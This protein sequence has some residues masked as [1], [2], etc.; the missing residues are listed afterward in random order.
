M[1]R[2]ALFGLLAVVLLGSLLLERRL[3]GTKT[4]P[5]ADG[6]TLELLVGDDAPAVRRS[7]P[8]EPPPVQ[9]RTVETPA[10]H[11]ASRAAPVPELAEGESL[12]AFCQRV[13]GSELYAESLAAANGLASPAA[14]KAGGKLELPRKETLEKRYRVKRN[15]SL[16]QIAERYLGSMKEADRLARWNHLENKNALRENQVLRIPD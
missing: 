9:A 15:D 1:R 12:E 16:S 4:I 6:D 3:T 7:A 5:P 8:I 14:A 2:L 13:Y 10:P 11:P